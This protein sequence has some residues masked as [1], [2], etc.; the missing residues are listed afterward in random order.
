MADFT[1]FIDESGCDGF[2]FEAG[3]SD[4]LVIA[5][6]LCR[7]AN[8]EQYNTALADARVACRKPKDWQFKSFKKMGS[9]P[10]QQW[11]ITESFAARSCQA[12]A[13]AV[14]KPGL[15]EDGWRENPGDLYFHASKY[16]V[17]RISFA[18]RD[19]HAKLPANDPRVRI[20]FSERKGL[21][22]DAFQGYLRRLRDEPGHNTNTSWAHIDPDL[23]EPLAHD[24]SHAALL[25]AD[26]L[27]AGLGLALERKDQGVFDDRFA[28]LWAAKFYHSQGRVVGNGL[29]IW[30]DSGLA[31]LRQ[32]A[33]GDWI[34]MALGLR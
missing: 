25:A 14:Y 30:P 12:V 29:K 31:F 23:V 16:L 5:A 28:R 17:E 22:Y 10:S 7:T 6:V 20:V 3:S 18:C 32:E 26:Y 33:R 9:S 34:K 8:V 4:F 2:S 15:I 24:D 27:S 19:T 1:A 13:V 11:A 21:R